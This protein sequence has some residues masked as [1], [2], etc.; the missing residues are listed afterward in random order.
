MSW[1]FSI[2]D[3]W[4]EIY[5]HIR[6]RGK[7]T[8]ASCVGISW[9]IFIMVIL[10]GIG[11]AFEEGI[12]KLFEDFNSSMVIV[13]AGTISE[14]AEG[15]VEGLQ[16]R[17]NKEDISQIRQNVADIEYISPLLSTWTTVSAKGTYGNFEV[18]GFDEDYMHII[19][20][21]LQRGRTLNRRD[22]EE[23]RRCAVIGK[24]V[25]TVLFKQTDCIGKEIY[26]NNMP[27]KVVGV[28]KGSPTSPGDERAVLIS[29][30]SYMAVVDNQPEYRQ[31]VYTAKEDRK[32]SEQ[33]KKQIGA[34]HR[35]KPSDKKAVY[36]MTM[37]DQL[38]AFDTLFSGIR[39][40]L[41]FVGISTL[42]G[43]VVGISNIMV[44][45]IRE[46]T[47]E[48]GV[49]M[50][51]GAT[52]NDIKKMIMGEGMAITMVAGVCG[53]IAGWAIL[54]AL[55]MIPRDDVVIIGSLLIDTGTTV[56]SMIVI[57]AAGLISGLR[58]AHIASSMNPINA[59]QSE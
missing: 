6:G 49:R 53:I 44:S 17:F 48:I 7:Q 14:P 51:M 9:G 58:P 50:A 28:F 46:R 19:S 15:S 16:I 1:L 57:L 25:E 31:L 43:G 24:N 32:I 35:F 36:I 47:K 56:F 59:L 26:I 55:N 54:Q 37:E 5:E 21:R 13:E 4:A 33:V 42:V 23:G 27:V 39:Y 20:Y 40:F 45:N 22:F 41:W 30:E 12:M 34:A 52:P 3:F 29:S 8:I 2:G 18:R 38:K 10:V 11:N